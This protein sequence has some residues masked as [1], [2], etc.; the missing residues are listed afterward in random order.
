[1]SQEP[2]QTINFKLPLD[3]D[4][5]DEDINEKQ[6]QFTLVDYPGHPKLRHLLYSSIDENKTIPGLIYVIDS[7][8]TDSKNI[9]SNA[10]FLLEILKRT[11]KRPGGVDILIACNKSE[12]F[13]SRPP[14]KIKELLQKEINELITI[15]S[16]GLNEV[17]L[18]D[19]GQEEEIDDDDEFLTG[20]EFRFEDLEGNVDF[21]AGSLIKGK[22]DKWDCWLNERAFNPT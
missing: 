19:K 3:H 17:S 6:S 8:A 20:R 5:S 9:T 2:N 15:K 13:S 10:N 12:S 16:K 21:I 1:M 18:N 11:E 7:S 14:F 22:I 4:T